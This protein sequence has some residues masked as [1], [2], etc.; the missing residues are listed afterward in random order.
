MNEWMNEWTTLAIS[1]A[2]NKLCS[3]GDAHIQS[4]IWYQGKLWVAFNDA[5]FITGDTKSHSCIRLKQVYTITN[6]VIQDIDIGTVASSLYY[7]AVS[8]SKG[9]GGNLGIIFRFSSPSDYPSS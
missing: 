7:P 4:D 9:T 1:L 6:K 2:P 8:I 3:T 5:C